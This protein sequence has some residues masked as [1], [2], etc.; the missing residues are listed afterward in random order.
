VPPL[1]H[2]ERLAT[3]K[4]SGVALIRL[5]GA[6]NLP[7]A[8]LAE[9]GVSVGEVA[10]L[11]VADPLAQ[12]G[13]TAATGV[14]ARLTT[15]GIEPAPKLGFSGAAAVDARGHVIGMVD[16]KSPVVAGGAATSAGAVLVP[17]ETIRAFLQAQRVTPAAGNAVANQSVL[18]LIC[19]RK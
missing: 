14:A 10:I 11:G 15:Q 13:E 3:D 17:V 4:A 6:R 5:Y 1:G 2:A 8:S 9:S 19:V 7:A 16:L 12:N 18:R